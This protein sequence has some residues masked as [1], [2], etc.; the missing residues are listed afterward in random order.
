MSDKIKPPLQADL[1]W[2]I[3]WMGSWRELIYF[4]FMQRGWIIIKKCN[5][6]AITARISC[7]A[8]YIAAYAAKSS[9]MAK[10]HMPDKSKTPLQTSLFRIFARNTSAFRL[11]CH[12]CMHT[13]CDSLRLAPAILGI[14]LQMQRDAS[15]DSVRLNCYDH[16]PR[17][18][19]YHWQKQLNAR[20]SMFPY[21]L[22]EKGIC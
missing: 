8:A 5:Y 19:T 14:P 15:R 9:L 20:H 7:C 21:K 13:D 3:E 11:H 10:R 6:S 18:R 16:L 4:A 22:L 2:I 1:R 12:D 17:R